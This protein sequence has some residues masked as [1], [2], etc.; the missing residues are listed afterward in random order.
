MT[1]WVILV[2]Q[3]KDLPTRDPQQGHYDERISCP[4][5]LFDM[6]RPS[7]SNLARSYA[8]PVEGVLCVA[9]RGSAR[10]PRGPRPVDEWLEL[11]E[12]KL[13][14]HALPDLDGRAHRCARRADLQR[15]VSSSS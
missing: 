8:L 1:G 7:W 2:D 11:R 13:Y 9:A 3:P 10:P 12:A 14:E 4:P 6:G 15:R 5:R